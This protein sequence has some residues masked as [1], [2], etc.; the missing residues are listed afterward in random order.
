MK[1]VDIK[2][3]LFNGI[4]NASSALLLITMLWFSHNNAVLR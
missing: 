4:T 2:V 1:P 3:S